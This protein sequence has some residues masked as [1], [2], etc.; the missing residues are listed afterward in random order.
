MRGKVRLLLFLGLDSWITPAY[1]GKR[2]RGIPRTYNERDH[3]RVCG[4][5]GD[6]YKMA[7]ENQGSPPRMRG[8]VIAMRFFNVTVGITPAYAGKRLP[9][10]SGY[11]RSQDHPRVCG[12]KLPCRSR[13]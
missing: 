2:V 3:P 6:F 10:F 12:E 11:I 5:K 8:K 4:E 13:P 1:A 9:V 7:M